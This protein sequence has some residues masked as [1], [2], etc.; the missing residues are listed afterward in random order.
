MGIFF[1][2]CISLPTTRLSVTSGI[3]TRPSMMTRKPTVG[4]GAASSGAC[5]HPSAW[6]A[7]RRLPW[8]R[9]FLAKAIRGPEPGAQVLEPLHLTRILGSP[10][11]A[12]VCSCP[13]S[14]SLEVRHMMMPPKDI[15]RHTHFPLCRARTG[16]SRDLASLLAHLAHWDGW[17]PSGA[18][19]GVFVTLAAQASQQPPA[20]ARAVPRRG[21]GGAK[22]PPAR[23]PCAR[24]R[25]ARSAHRRTHCCAQ[26]A[27]PRVPRHC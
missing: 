19:L 15:S 9:R 23:A 18:A 16:S 1:A 3:G 13:S 6:P 12:Y 10:P 5:G 25:A 2:C 17:V 4:D 21:G 26:C 7:L 11:C 22:R 24:D 20:W 14:K 27:C 8:P